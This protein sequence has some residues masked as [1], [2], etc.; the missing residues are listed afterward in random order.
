[1][2]GHGLRAALVLDAL[3]CFPLHQQAQDTGLGRDRQVRPGTHGR[4]EIAVRRALPPAVHDVHVV[5]RHAL[6]DRPVRVLEATVPGLDGCLVEVFPQLFARREGRDAHRPMR[7]AVGGVPDRLLTLLEER[8]ETLVVPADGAGPLPR[9]VGSPVAA[10]V[11][12]AVDA[13]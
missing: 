11:H 13:A 9:V 8:K 12:H 5:P 6:G 3:A 7:A 10:Y 2:D 1:M 4:R